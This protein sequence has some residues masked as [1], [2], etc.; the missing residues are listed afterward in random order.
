MNTNSLENMRDSLF[1]LQ[2]FV[3]G[4]TLKEVINKQHKQKQQRRPSK[5]YTFQDAFRWLLQIAEAIAYLHA[6]K[7]IVM[8]RDL[9]PENILLTSSDPHVADVKLVDFGLHRRIKNILPLYKTQSQTP[10]STGT[11]VSDQ[12]SDCEVE[13][14]KARSFLEDSAKK[15]GGHRLLEAFFV[16]GFG[17]EVVGDR[18]WIGI[19]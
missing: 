9:K 2:E 15:S 12:G 19:V 18:Q 17:R 13:K 10:M 7:P 4:G 3:G 8:H 5:H 1:I 16:G 6:Q 14:L 11:I